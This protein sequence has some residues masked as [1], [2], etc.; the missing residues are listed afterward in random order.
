M[1]GEL[2][3]DNNLFSVLFE[4]KIVNYCH[5]NTTATTTTTKRVT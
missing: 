3:R 2:P 5:L 4:S 1:R